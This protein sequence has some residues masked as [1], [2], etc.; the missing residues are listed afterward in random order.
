MN[1]IPGPQ[2][3]VGRGRRRPGLTILSRDLLDRQ[4]TLVTFNIA[5][6]APDTDR[7]AGHGLSHNGN[8][9]GR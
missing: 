3:G 1:P 6:Q 4:L 2:D 8:V 9:T 5:G 7:P